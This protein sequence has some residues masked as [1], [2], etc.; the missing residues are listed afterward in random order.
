MANISNEKLPVAV[1]III[2]QKVNPAVT[3][4]DLKR[5]DDNSNLKS[6]K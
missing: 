2:N 1:V 3:A 5:G 4:T 6:D